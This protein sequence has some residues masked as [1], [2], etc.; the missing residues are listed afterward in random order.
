VLGGIVYCCSYSALI[1]APFAVSSAITGCIKWICLNHRRV[2]KAITKTIAELHNRKQLFSTLLFF[3]AIPACIAWTVYI[4]HGISGWATWYLQSD[5]A[6]WALLRSWIP[7]VISV[8]S[9]VAG[10][11]NANRRGNAKLLAACYGFL[12][13][14]VFIIPMTWSLEP[15]LETLLIF[16]K[17]AVPIFATYTLCI[18]PSFFLPKLLAL[19]IDLL[20]GRLKKENL[21]DTKINY[22][23]E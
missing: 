12:L 5:H 15:F 4:Y 16:I 11:V 23:G 21:K 10:I 2:W 13:L 19:G 17:K 8:F 9:I 14:T 7:L 18:V 3:L 22:T 6:F 20:N 1:L